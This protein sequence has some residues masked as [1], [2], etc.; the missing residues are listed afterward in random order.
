MTWIIC[1]FVY[2]TLTL[3]HQFYNPHPNNYT[4]QCFNHLILPNIAMYMCLSSFIFRPL[5]VSVVLVKNMPSSVCSTSGRHWCDCHDI[6]GFLFHAFSSDW[7]FLVAVPWSLSF[8]VTSREKHDGASQYF[9]WWNTCVVCDWD[10]QVLS[11]YQ[12]GSE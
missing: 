10:V 9:W 6:L 2:I 5:W 8:Q 4:S 3:L 1:I 7:S 11:D 12:C